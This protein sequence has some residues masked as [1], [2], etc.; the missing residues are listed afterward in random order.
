MYNPIYRIT[1]SYQQTILNNYCV[2]LQ[3]NA[4]TMTLKLTLFSSSQFSACYSRERSPEE[5]RQEN[6]ARQTRLRNR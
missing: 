1:Q 6:G 2:V 5:G 4:F 3:A